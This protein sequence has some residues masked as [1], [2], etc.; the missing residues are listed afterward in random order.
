[1]LLRVEAIKAQMAGMAGEFGALQQR[2]RCYDGYTGRLLA[3]DDTSVADV[4]RHP[5]TTAGI[6]PGKGAEVGP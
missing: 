1:M 6:T 3:C 2:V 4:L 5:A